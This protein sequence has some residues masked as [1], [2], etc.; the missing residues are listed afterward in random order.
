MIN[1]LELEEEFPIDQPVRSIPVNTFS[2]SKTVRREILSPDGRKAINVE[3]DWG[4]R[5]GVWYFI[6]MITSRQQK[7]NP[8][9]EE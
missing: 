1:V 7:T 5:D 9:M 6:K 3:C 2:D 4:L 8:L